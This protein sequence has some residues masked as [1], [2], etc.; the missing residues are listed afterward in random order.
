MERCVFLFVL[1]LHGPQTYLKKKKINKFQ[2]IQSDPFHP[3]MTHSTPHYPIRFRH[4][5][6]RALGRSSSW[7]RR[8]GRTSARPGSWAIARLCTKGNGFR[9]QSGI[10]SKLLNSIKVRS[11]DLEAHLMIR[12]LDWTCNIF[13]WIDLIVVLS[14]N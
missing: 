9:I 10:L 2:S 11:F 5:H 14:G 13:N 12:E 4:V 7:R 6:S 1:A 3:M 8:P